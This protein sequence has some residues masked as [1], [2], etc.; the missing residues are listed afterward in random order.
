MYRVLC[1][2]LVCLF[3]VRSRKFTARKYLKVFY[4]FNFYLTFHIY[5]KK[6]NIVNSFLLLRKGKS[7]GHPCTGTEALYRPY[8]Q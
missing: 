4:Y 3:R 8:G 5:F 1:N 7:K 6:E 2:L